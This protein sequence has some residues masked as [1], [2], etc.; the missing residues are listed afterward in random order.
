MVR[1]AISTKARLYNLAKAARPLRSYEANEVY[2][3]L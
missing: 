3:K 1:E 2:A